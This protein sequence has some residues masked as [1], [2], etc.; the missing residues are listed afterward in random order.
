MKSRRSEVSQG[1]FIIFIND[2][3]N[4]IF[5]NLFKFADDAKL[6]E[7]ISLFELKELKTIENKLFVDTKYRK[8]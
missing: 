2:L 7:K 4:D 5:N 6:L 8:M 3:D 1:S